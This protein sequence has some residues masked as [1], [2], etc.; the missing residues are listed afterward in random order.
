M[1]IELFDIVNERDEIVGTTH[2]QESHAKG[3]IHRVV[4]VYVFDD[5]GRLYVQHHKKSRMLD[6][7]VGG[8]VAQGETYDAAA[9]REAQEE[10]GIFDPLSYVV[11]LYSD[12]TYCGTPIRHMFALYTCT[13]SSTWRFV[14]NEEVEVIQPMTLENIVSQMNENP[15]LF[16]PGFLN[17]M[18][19]YLGH[20]D[21][22]LVLDLA[23]VRQNGY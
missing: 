5:E 18:E 17:S 1:S 8:H 21:S 6:H 19:F 2:K 16:T 22:E 13:P 4:V 3:Y 11:T 10:L 20:I 12:E 7:S 23:A 14:A 9:V 15:R